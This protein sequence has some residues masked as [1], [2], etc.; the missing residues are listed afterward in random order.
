[1]DNIKR[2]PTERIDTKQLETLSYKPADKTLHKEPTENQNTILISTIESLMSIV[3]DKL[4][5]LKTSKP[6]E[7]TAGALYDRN[8][9]KGQ[10]R[11]DIDIFQRVMIPKLREA[12]K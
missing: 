5:K 12:F 7:L 9:I 6:Y 8:T 1:M 2:K 4:G 3:N 10:A 11:D